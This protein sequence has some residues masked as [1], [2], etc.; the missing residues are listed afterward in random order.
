MSFRRTLSIVL[1]GVLLG[2]LLTPAGTRAQVEDRIWGRVHTGS[3]QVHEGFL[4]WDRNEGVWADLLNGYKEAAP[5]VFEDWWRLAHPEDRHRDRVIEMAGYR[6]TWDDDAPDFTS[7]HESGVRF[8]HIRTLTPLG[9]DTARVELRSGREVI[10]TGG[11]T[12]LGTEL[13][14][15][16]VFEEGGR[17][18]RLGWEDLERVELLAPPPG[19]TAEGRRLHATAQLRDGPAFT[20]Y[21]SWD[22]NEAF[23][24]DTLEGFGSRLRGGDLLFGRVVSIR[25]RED[26][27]RVTLDDGSEVELP[28]AVELDWGRT[29][30]QISDPALGMVEV[31]WED[32]EELRFHPPSAPTRME[33]YDGGRRLRGTVV[34]ADS[35]EL[36]GW[37]RWDA[38]EEYTWEI[39]DGRDGDVGFDVELGQVTAI[40]RTESLTVTL[41]VGGRG[42]DVGHNRRGGVLVTLRDGRTFT[43]DG[44]NDVDEDNQGILVLEEGSGLSPD[45]P[46]AVWILLRWRDFRAVRF[47]G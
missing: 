33:D 25:P 37:I 7:R 9:N 10:L 38:D 23:T 29:T 19:A 32:L 14:E 13:R 41:S 15:V 8:G 17:V 4:R 18:V 1:P 2:L 36:T 22:S 12:D 28:E 26:G 30:L 24:T 11:A 47:E 39:L 43:L 31:E 42:A 16:L 45:D 44:S 40:E 5:L 20:G 35:T 46:E 27:A 3:G 21:L 6:I 34:T